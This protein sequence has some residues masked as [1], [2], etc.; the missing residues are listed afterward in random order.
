[1]HI[2]FNTPPG[3][4]FYEAIENILN[5]VIYIQQYLWINLIW[6]GLICYGIFKKDNE[7]IYGGI[8]SI[9]FSFGLIYILLGF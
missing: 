1:M 7:F 4:T 2:V 5:V 9:I 6:F 8:F 3:Y